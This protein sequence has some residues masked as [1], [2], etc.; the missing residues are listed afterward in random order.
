[1]ELLQPFLFVAIHAS[2]KISAVLISA[3]WSLD[4]HLSQTDT[5][6]CIVVLLGFF[7]IRIRIAEL[8]N[9]SRITAN[10]FDT[11]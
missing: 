5:S 6:P 1:M 3:V 11:K 7:L 8:L 10:D 2:L 4:Q 9:A